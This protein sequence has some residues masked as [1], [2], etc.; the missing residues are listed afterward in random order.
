[1]SKNILWISKKSI[2]KETLNQFENKF[3]EFWVGRHPEQK[4]YEN[5]DRS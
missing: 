2:T 4:N 5:I 3:I 1:M